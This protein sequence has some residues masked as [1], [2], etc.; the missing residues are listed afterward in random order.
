MSFKDTEETVA[1]ENA[2]EK[3]NPVSNWAKTIE[4]LVTES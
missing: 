4:S 3:R 2:K 1:P